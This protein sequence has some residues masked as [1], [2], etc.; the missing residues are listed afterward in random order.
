[1]Q[2]IGETN[3]KTE[4]RQFLFRK[5]VK[6]GMSGEEADTRIKT[7]ENTLHELVMK[8]RKQK[9]SERDI[10]ARFKKEFAKLCKRVI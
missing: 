7:I 3:M 9:M 5:F 4:E 1:M 2:R 6:K 10:N 8:L